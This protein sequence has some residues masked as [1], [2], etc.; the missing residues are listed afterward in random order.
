MQTARAAQV[1]T[2]TI[3]RW[4]V[5]SFGGRGKPRRARA[6]AVLP[7][8]MARILFRPTVRCYFANFCFRS[9][10]TTFYVFVGPVRRNTCCPIAGLDVRARLRRPSCTV[11]RRNTYKIKMWIRILIMGLLLKEKSLEETSLENI[12]K[13]NKTKPSFY[14]SD[15]L[16][17]GRSPVFIFYIHVKFNSN[18]ILYL[19]Y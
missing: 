15:G 13:I 17:K 14:V 7:R 3:H 9:T 5:T 6:L 19:L 2:Q 11:F 18:Y 10:I 4:V 12:K 16:Y 1:T 8:R